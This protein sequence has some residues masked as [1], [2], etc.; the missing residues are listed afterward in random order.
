MEGM[1]AMLDRLI[2]NFFDLAAFS[3]R[4]LVLL[5]FLVS[6]VTGKPF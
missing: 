5:V 6:F 4:Y 2:D 1:V 3:L